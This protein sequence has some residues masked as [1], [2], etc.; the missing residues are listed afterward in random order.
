V[1][2]LSSFTLNLPHNGLFDFVNLTVTVNLAIHIA[3]RLT[4]SYVTLSPLAR[5]LTLTT[6]FPK[7]SG[8]AV[9]SGSVRGATEAGPKRRG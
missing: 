9:Q 8:R 2:A 4:S 7:Q 6:T 3:E 5:I 1:I